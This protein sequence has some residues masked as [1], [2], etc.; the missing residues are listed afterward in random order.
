M[1]V[2]EQKPLDEIVEALEGVEKLVLVGCQGCPQGWESG[3]PEKV[4]E[5]G[6][7]LAERG[8]TIVGTVMIDFLCNK[9]LVGMRL[10]RRIEELKEA[11]ALLVVACGVGVQATAAMVDKPCHP[12]LNTLSS[13]GFQGLWPSEERCGQCG[14]CVLSLTG[15][16]CPITTCAKSM[17]NGPCGGSHK[18]HCEV[19]PNRPCGWNRIYERLKE[20][21]RLDNL[22]KMPRIRNHRNMDIPVKLRSTIRWA[23][24]ATE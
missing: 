16:I 19:E 21:G 20:Q 7:K 2:T 17:L 4:A 14:D 9:A 15:G 10:R 22:K 11:D 24:E 13:G 1:L 12:A 23:I 6:D 5:L 18:G 3:G 8:K